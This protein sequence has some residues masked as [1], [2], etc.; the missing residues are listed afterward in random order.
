MYILILL[1]KP[2]LHIVILEP[3]GVC[4]YSSRTLASFS[5]PDVWRI[6]CCPILAF[7]AHFYISGFR[8]RRPGQL[9]ER[10]GGAYEGE[11]HTH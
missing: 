11:A 2:V 7:S 3:V 4:K 8:Q 5:F 9:S 10:H 1:D 6:F